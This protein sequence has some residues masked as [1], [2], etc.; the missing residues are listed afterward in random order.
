MEIFKAAR[1][2]EE[3]RE[4]QCTSLRKQC[5]LPSIESIKRKKYCES[6]I[7]H[8]MKLFF[9]N[10]GKR[11]TFSHMQKLKGFITITPALQ[12]ILEE[13]LQDG[14]MCKVEISNCTREGRAWMIVSLRRSISL[15]LS[16]LE[17]PMDRG[18]WWATSP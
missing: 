14:L 6:L 11:N 3:Q 4:H 12:E 7:L 16:Y 15:S 18:A 10:K 13:G 5:S 9:K 8:L 17:N 1:E 2:T